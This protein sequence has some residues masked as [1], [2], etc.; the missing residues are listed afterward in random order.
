[1]FL[2]AFVLTCLVF[3]SFIAE[4]SLSEMSGQDI[5]FLR[6]VFAFTVFYS[7]SPFFLGLMCVGVQ[8]CP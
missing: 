1:M 3:T 2:N 7:L 8:R 5:A 6:F 4:G